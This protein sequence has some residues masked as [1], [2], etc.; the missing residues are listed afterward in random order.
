MKGSGKNFLSHQITDFHLLFYRK[1]FGKGLILN[2]IINICKQMFRLCLTKISKKGVLGVEIPVEIYSDQK[3]YYDRQCPNPE[4]EYVFKIFMEDWKEKVSDEEVHCPMCGHIASSGEWFTYEQLDEMESIA[5]EWA[6]GLIQ[7]EINKIFTNLS[8]STRHNKFLKVSYKPSKK[9]TFRNNPIGQREEW[10]VD[11][12]CEDCGTRYSVIGS[13][14]FCP[15]CG[16]NAVDNVFDESLDTIQKMIDSKNEMFIT[17][18]QMYGRD[19]ADTMCRSMLEGS[20][21]DLVSTFQ[22]FALERYSKLTTK[23]VRPNDFQI[24]EKGCTLFSEASGQG[25][26]SWLSEMKL[27]I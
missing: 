13:A 9:I 20:L 27:N 22:K 11:I 24:V 18:E 6:M 4:C 10:E 15:C 26:D 2:G 16:H 3:G 5:S 19:K 8:S 1:G 17:F 7:G 21:A 23:K 25:Y 14:Y 12:T